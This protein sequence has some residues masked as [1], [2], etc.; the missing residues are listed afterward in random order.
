M[1][2]F[3]FAW[4]PSDPSD[5]GPLI[6]VVVMNSVDV[7]EAWRAVGLECPQAVKMK[8]LIDTGAA[9]TVISKAA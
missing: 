9:V 6:D 3:S 5:P 7:L 4:D 8:A 2:R 1:G